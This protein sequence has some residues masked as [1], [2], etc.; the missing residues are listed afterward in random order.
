MNIGAEERLGVALI[1]FAVCVSGEMPRAETRVDRKVRYFRLGLDLDGRPGS[2]FAGEDDIHAVVRRAPDGTD[3]S[4][5]IPEEL[6]DRSR[7]H[8]SSAG[9][10]DSLLKR[11]GPLPKCGDRAVE[12][13]LRHA[14]AAIWGD[15]SSDSGL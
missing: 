7:F 3:V 15:E 1:P 2:R 10:L 8:P 9:L 5:L 6:S 4:E 12:Q 14:L 13:D 11:K